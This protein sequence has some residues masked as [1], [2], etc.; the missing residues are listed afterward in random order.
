MG[1]TRKTILALATKS[2]DGPSLLSLL[3]LFLHW[4]QGTYDIRE[5]A[6]R[7]EGWKEGVLF[8]VKAYQALILAL[9]D[10]VS[11][12]CG[13]RPFVRDTRTC[14][15]QRIPSGL[16][17]LPA[18]HEQLTKLERRDRLRRPSRRFYL[19]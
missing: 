1:I 8:D 18:N 14:S 3:D 13:G 12:S 7:D 4:D 5:A 9:L 10:G 17:Q 6:G 16:S 11:Y 15:R 2:N 19:G